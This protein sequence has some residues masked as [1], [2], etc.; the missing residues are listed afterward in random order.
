[1]KKL[2]ITGIA[3]VAVA[4]VAGMTAL[5][6]SALGSDTTTHANGSQSGMQMRDGS[7]GG[8]GANGAGGQQASLE[9]RAQVLSMTATELQTALETKTLSQIAVE[10][11]LSEEVFEQKMNEAAQA[12]W[13]VRGLSSEEVA[14][15]VADQAARRAANSV[16]H[17]FGSG[18]GDR[19]NGYGY[20]RNQ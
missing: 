4:G 11:G 10:K 15:R 7:G 18:E 8:S 12:R 9:S 13:E 3:A 16:D 19:E 17:E 14:Q 6:A 5:D 2:I 20:G 1:M